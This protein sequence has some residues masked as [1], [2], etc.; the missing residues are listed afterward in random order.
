MPVIQVIRRD[1]QAIGQT[2]VIKLLGMKTPSTAILRMAHCPLCVMKAVLN[3]TD[4]FVLHH[5]DLYA[6]FSI[7]DMLDDVMPSH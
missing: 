6:D 7:N 1:C 2:E 3:Y 5:A 4:A